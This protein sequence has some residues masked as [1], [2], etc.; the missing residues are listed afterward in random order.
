M[1]HAHTH[2]PVYPRTRPLA[3]THA[4][5]HTNPH[6][7]TYTNKRKHT[8]ARTRARTHTHTHTHTHILSHPYNNGKY[9]FCSLNCY[10]S[11]VRIR[12]VR[13]LRACRAG[14]MGR[15]TQFKSMEAG[16]KEMENISYRQIGPFVL[17]V[18]FLLKHR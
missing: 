16:G 5:T 17:V 18:L 7:R 10:P 15:V 9:T 4:R 12:H 3:R 13:C 6:S 1:K 2:R 11:S 8:H 14:T